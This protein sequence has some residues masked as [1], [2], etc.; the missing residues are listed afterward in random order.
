MP[1]RSKTLIELRDF[2]RVALLA[3]S[4][5]TVEQADVVVKIAADAIR[6]QWGG[7][8]VFIPKTDLEEMDARDW[9]IWEEFDGRNYAA[10]GRKFGLSERQVYNRIAVIR[11]I[12]IKRVQGNLFAEL[13]DEQAQAL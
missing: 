2:L 1:P 7:D 5:F 8:S 6:R 9:K 10:V 11:T 13:E 3:D 12:A 4:R